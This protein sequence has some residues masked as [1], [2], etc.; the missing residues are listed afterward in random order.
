VWSFPV[1][2]SVSEYDAQYTNSTTTGAFTGFNTGIGFFY[3][4]AVGWDVKDG[5]VQI[6][7]TPPAPP[8]ATIAAPADDQTYTVGQSVQTS[9]SCQ[10]GAGGPG[11]D[12]CTDSNGANAAAA[13]SATATGTGKL[14][15]ATAGLFSYTVTAKSY[16]GLTGS[17]NISYAV[18]N[19][20][21]SNRFTVSRVKA[22]P[23]G[24]V[25]FDVKVPGRGTINVLETAWKNNLARAASLLQPA[26]GRFVFA[27]AHL[28]AKRRG[29]VKVKVTPYALGKRLVYH[30]TYKVR[31]RLW[32]TFT[33]AGGRARSVGL[34]GQKITGARAPR[35]GH[36]VLRKPEPRPGPARRSPSRR[37]DPS[38]PPLLPGSE[39][40]RDVTSSTG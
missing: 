8:S 3:F 1:T 14:N 19:A 38:H 5:Q 40:N 36:P 7:P 37:G 30:H 25:V 22:F 20:S 31:I 29:T 4:N 28:T 6:T 17:A 12:S 34:Y 26:R 10:E 39:E 35:R 15:T 33:P 11:L 16:D 32:V 18:V 13:G 9:F 24:T 23:D 2:S 21:P 27:R